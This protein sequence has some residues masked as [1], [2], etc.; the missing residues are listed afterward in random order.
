M[1]DLN[2]SNNNINVLPK[3]V[4][5]LINLKLLWVSSNQIESLPSEIGSRSIA[6]CR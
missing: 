6:G 3:E 4:G 2:L 1:K 5:E